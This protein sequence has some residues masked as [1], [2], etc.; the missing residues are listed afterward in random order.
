MLMTA[1]CMP[2]QYMETLYDDSVDERV[3]GA[4]MILQLARDPGLL[5]HILGNGAMMRVCV[6]TYADVAMWRI[7]MQSRCWEPCPGH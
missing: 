4:G 6:H 5:Q 1:V 7:G 2:L 3:K